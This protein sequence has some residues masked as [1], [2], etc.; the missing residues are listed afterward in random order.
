MAWTPSFVSRPSPGPL[1]AERH[2]VKPE[3]FTRFLFRPNWFV[4]AQTDGEDLEPIPIPEWDR[5]RALENAGRRR[6]AFHRN[7]WQLPRL[8]TTAIDRGVANRGLSQ[9]PETICPLAPTAGCMIDH[10]A[11]DHADPGPDT[12]AN[13]NVTPRRMLGV[14]RHGRQR[15]PPNCVEWV[16]RESDRP[17]VMALTTGPCVVWSRMANNIA[18]SVVACAPTGSTDARDR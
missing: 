18:A 8:R 11:Q 17:A 16:R 13:Q 2:G 15:A 1:A 6:R 5:L 12:R 3:A 9:C 4:L 14:H 10:G 7:G